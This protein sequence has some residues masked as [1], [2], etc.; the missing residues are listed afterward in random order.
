M[1]L[2]FQPKIVNMYILNLSTGDIAGMSITALLLVVLLVGLLKKKK[3]EEDHHMVYE[4]IKTAPPITYEK[5]SS[6]GVEEAEA[7]YLSPVERVADLFNGTTIWEIMSILN[8]PFKETC[9]AA[10]AKE[11][12]DAFDNAESDSEVEYVAFLK[13][14]ELE[15]DFDRMDD[16]DSFAEDFPYLEKV[17]NEKR[18]ILALKK[19]SEYSTEEE[20][21]PFMDEVP[22]NSHAEKVILQK[23]LAIYEEK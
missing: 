19:I 12:E 3:V 5:Q 9:L 11:A 4:S 22:E 8:I 1:L 2:Y 16:L 7:T 10:T 21:V 6:V 17:V 14:I 15:D 23:L 20:L 13:W 18:N